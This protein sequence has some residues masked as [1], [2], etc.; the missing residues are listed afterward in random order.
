MKK[1]V[2]I[3]SLVMLFLANV[4]TAQFSVGLKAGFASN[5][6]SAE[7][8]IDAVNTAPKGYTSAIWGLTAEVPLHQNISILTELYKTRKGFTME[9]STSFQVL[10]IH[11]PVGGSVTTSLSYIETPI[12]L[13]ASIGSPTVQGYGLLG[14]SMAYATSAVIS[15]R[16]TLLIN[17]NLPEIEID[18]SNDVYNRWNTSAVVGGGAQFS[19]GRGKIFVDARYQLGL[20]DL[21]DSPTVD[22]KLRNHSL[23]FSTGYSITF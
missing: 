11:V 7:F 22:L 10:G 9:E 8:Y 2:F 13:K 18:L 14:A 1:L 12:L 3:I 16:A 21:I 23:M 20:N 17:F 6:V 19:V 15:P 5:D 4:V